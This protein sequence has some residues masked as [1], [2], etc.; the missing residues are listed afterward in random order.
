[1]D[2]R[3]RIFYE[4]TVVGMLIMSTAMGTGTLVAPPMQ[5]AFENGEITIHLDGKKIKGTFSLILM[6]NQ[7][8]PKN[9]LLIKRDDQ[10]A[11]DKFDPIIE[12]PNSVISHKSIEEI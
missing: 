5:D 10:D 11:T 9:W 8:E 1:M 12:L 4:P 3:K 2:G 7:D 6:K